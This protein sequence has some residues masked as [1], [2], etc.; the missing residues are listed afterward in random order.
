[1]ARGDKEEF[2]FR[3]VQ[4]ALFNGPD[5]FPKIS[6]LTRKTFADATDQEFENGYGL[7][8]NSGFSKNLF[9]FLE[10]DRIEFV[11]IIRTARSNPESN[12]FPDL[13]FNGGF[14][15][16]FQITSSKSSKRKGSIQE[17]AAGKIRRAE[18]AQQKEWEKDE[19]FTGTQSKSWVVEATEHSYDYLVTSFR[20]S[21]DNHISSLNN[22]DGCK[23]IG[24]FMIEY[25]DIAL[26]MQELKYNAWDDE[27]SQGDFHSEE[28][29]RCYR[30]TRDKQLLNYIYGFRDQIKYVIFVYQD[31][32]EAIKLDSIP[33][34]LALMPWDY[35]IDPLEQQTT[36]TL[37]HA[38][39]GINL[40]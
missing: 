30:L 8:L 20:R 13:I 10:E 27:M 3:I 11:K 9:G 19:S 5:G 16:H 2:C 21:W 33:K 34:L 31:H 26:S 40:T 28:Q 36:Y 32:F 17:Q 4:K 7:Y 35:Q 6:P 1:M 12:N 39:F 24:I 18:T 37:H 29:H 15:E 22:Y 14:I 23:E 25:P 38:R